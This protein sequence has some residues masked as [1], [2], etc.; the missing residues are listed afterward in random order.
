MVRRLLV[1]LAIVGLSGILPAS[2]RADGDSVTLPKGIDN[3]SVGAEWYLSY[4]NG[5]S[6]GDSYNNFVIKRGYIN[7]VK[8]M[9]PWLEGRI[10]PDVTQDASGSVFLRLKYAYA[11]FKS[12]SE[13]FI[14]KP[15]VEFGLAHTPWLDWEEHLNTYRLQDTMFSERNGNFNSA[16]FG[17]TFGGFFGGE[18]SKDYQ[19]AA[20]SAYPGRFGSFAV[21]VY[22]G[23]GYHAVEKNENKVVEGRVTVRPA[24]DV[25]P[26]LQFSYFGIFGDGNVAPTDEMTA[27]DWRFNLGLV[28]YEDARVVLAGQFVA[29]TGN[30]GGSRVDADGKAVDNGGYSVFGE[31]KIHEYKSSVIARFDHYDPNKDADNDQNDRFIVGYAYHLV[32]HNMILLDVER[33]TFE[34]SSK[35]AN[36]RFQTTVQVAY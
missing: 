22:N 35:D 6:G 34:D 9:A 26:G 28:S 23:G 3:L 5:K 10:T 14:Y 32:G 31:L 29:A 21:G 11:K 20:T 16:D 17:V 36:T 1:A 12:P 13:S 4:Q 27:P 24:P 2:L 8:K 33:Q 15:W 18:T 30:Q 7:V 25:V 19:K